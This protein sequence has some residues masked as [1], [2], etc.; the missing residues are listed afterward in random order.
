M[1]FRSTRSSFIDSSIQICSKKALNPFLVYCFSEVSLL[2]YMRPKPNEENVLRI[3]GMFLNKTVGTTSSK[4]VTQIESLSKGLGTS[5]RDPSNS[6][7]QR[8]ARLV[9]KQIIDLLNGFLRKK[10]PITKY[11][12]SD[13]GHVSIG[14]EYDYPFLEIKHKVADYLKDFEDNFEYFT[15]YHTVGQHLKQDFMLSVDITDPADLSHT[16]TEHHPTIYIKYE[17][18]RSIFSKPFP[19]SS[20]TKFKKMMKQVY[21]LSR[22]HGFFKPS[23]VAKYANLMVDFYVKK[24]TVLGIRNSAREFYVS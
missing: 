22:T 12:D 24:K 4:A 9:K 18:M 3:I 10:N 21:N 13:K 15:Y 20:R 11:I 17:D 19:P 6:P 1:I 2:D 5:L 7:K 8:Q 14:L 23:E 16:S